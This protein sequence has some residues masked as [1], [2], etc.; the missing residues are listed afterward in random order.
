M[1]RPRRSPWSPAARDSYECYY[2]KLRDDRVEAGGVYFCPN[3]LCTG[4]GATP[5]RRKLKSYVEESNGHSIDMQELVDTYWPKIAELG[6]DAPLRQAA[7][8]SVKLM[9]ERGWLTTQENGN[10]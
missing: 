10:G 4:C 7:E 1:A 5:H 8:R 2:C 6:A 3:P 9:R